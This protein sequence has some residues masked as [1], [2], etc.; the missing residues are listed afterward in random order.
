MVY[1]RQIPLTGGSNMRD[2]GGLPLAGGGQ[3]RRGKIYRSAALN[4]LT[5][6]DVALLA[7]MGLATVVDLRSTAEQAYAPSRLP[8]GLRVIAPGDGG[9]GAVPGHKWRPNPATEGQAR[10]M[11]REG[12]RTYPERMVPAVAATFEALAY[13]ESGGLLFHC[14]AGKD[15]TGFVAAVIL[16]YLGASEETVMEDY[17]ATNL[18]WDR[19]SARISGMPERAREAVFSARAEYLGAALDEMV[20]RYGS[21]TTYLADRCG[22]AV[23][24]L[25]RAKESLVQPA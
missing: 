9:V 25:E 20:A 8:A 1:D 13:A 3:V 16:L 23:P 17:L 19:K 22:I 11:M 10:R 2:L 21:H 6:E 12:N 4:T 24:V 15:R 7:S 5:D 14:A 18:I